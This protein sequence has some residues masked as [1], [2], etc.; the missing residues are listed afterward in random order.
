MTLLQI[1]AAIMLT[2]TGALVVW[3]IR[4]CDIEPEAPAAPPARAS[5]PQE[6]P[7]RR[8]A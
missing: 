8:A 6:P 7:L 2:C 3:A 5:R 1:V 4:L